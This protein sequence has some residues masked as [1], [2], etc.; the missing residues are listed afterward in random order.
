SNMGSVKSST[1]AAPAANKGEEGKTS[2]TLNEFTNKASSILR[3]LSS[4]GHS[5]TKSHESMKKHFLSRSKSTDIDARALPVQKR[6][7]E[8]PGVRALF[9]NAP[10]LGPPG[11]AVHSGAGRPFSAI[12]EEV[13]VAPHSAPG[14]KKKRRSSL[15][16]LI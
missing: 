6:P 8:R 9:D 12:Y 3:T 11:V 14:R 16:D 10:D 5:H 1:S 15:S 2:S 13:A 4:K 7:V